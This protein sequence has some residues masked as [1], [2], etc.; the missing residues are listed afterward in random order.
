M[1]PGA[2]VYATA[3]GPVVLGSWS[4]GGRDSQVHCILCS[5]FFQGVD[6]YD[7]ISEEKVT[8]QR[9]SLNC[10]QIHL[11]NNFIIIPSNGEFLC[12]HRTGPGILEYVCVIPFPIKHRRVC[13]SGNEKTGGIELLEG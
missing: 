4:Y 9:L 13:L 1:V 10:T 11:Y 6:E 3:E 5:D 2:S 12:Y 8:E 7:L